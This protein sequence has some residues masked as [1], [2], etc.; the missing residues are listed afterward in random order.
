V[1]NSRNGNLWNFII[2]GC[3]CAGKLDSR[4]GSKKVVVISLVCLITATLG[5]V[6]TGPGYT[7]FE[8]VSLSSVDSGGLFGTEAEKVY[9]LFGLLVGLVFGPAQASSRSYLARSVSVDEA[10][11]FFGLYALSGR[12]TS[13]AAPMLVATITLATDSARL[14]MS[15]LIVFLIVGFLLL[16]RTPYPA[17]KQEM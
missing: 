5:I 8:L 11:R 13:F 17:L 15:V 12:A 6:S 7:L 9:I 2:G 14:G 10:G 16:L 4:I 1:A 3:Y